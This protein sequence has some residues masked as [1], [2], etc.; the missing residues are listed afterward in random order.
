MFEVEVKIKLRDR[1]EFL[2]KIKDLGGKI[3]ARLQHTDVYYNAPKE[4]RDFAETD[5]ALRIRKNIEFQFDGEQNTNKIIKENADITYK[6]PKL[7]SETKSRVEH[8]CQIRHSGKMDHILLALGFRKIIS[9]EKE[10]QM[11]S[12]IFQDTSIDITLDKIQHLEGD[13]AE[14]EIIIRNEEDMDRSKHLIFA[15]MEKLGYSK[16]D[17]ITVSYL[18]LVLA[19]LQST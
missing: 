19:N 8:V 12:L 4:L 15:L 10:R 17:S 14:F 2:D 7:D 6:G 5:E 13:Y 16:S 11:F 1:D 9:I 18:E 3:E